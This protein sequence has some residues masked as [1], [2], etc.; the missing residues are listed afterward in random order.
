MKVIKLED[1]DSIKY[2]A[3]KTTEASIKNEY[4]YLVAEKLTQK[5]LEKGLIS[6]SE[7]AKIMAKNREIFSPF[8]AEIMG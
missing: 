4:D 1:I 6:H 2:E 3:D 5:L 8:L 7:Y